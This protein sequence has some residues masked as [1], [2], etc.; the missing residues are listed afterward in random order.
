MRLAVD[1]S[2]ERQ[3]IVVVIGV[4][5]KPALFH[6]QRS[7]TLTGAAG[8]PA[9]RPLTGQAA[10]NLN[11]TFQVFALNVFGYIAVINPAITVRADFMPCRHRR[12]CHGRVAFERHGH[13]EHRERNLVSLEK[14]EKTP[15]PDPRAILIDRLHAGMTLS[16]PR[17]GSDDF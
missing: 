15:Y 2:P 16:R 12:L 14:I 17:R 9:Q 7:G 13:A 5:K 1:S 3:V 11:G 10:N 6:N 4:V 8:I